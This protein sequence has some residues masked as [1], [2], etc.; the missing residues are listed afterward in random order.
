MGLE[1][2]LNA[3]LA[4]AAVTQEGAKDATKEAKKIR[5][6]SKDLEEQLDSMGTAEAL[7]NLV[8]QLGSTETEDDLKKLFDEIDEDKSGTLEVE[9]LQ[10]VFK[11]KLKIEKTKEEIEQV[12]AEVKGAGGDLKSVDLAHFR[13][14]VDNF[15]AAAATIESKDAASS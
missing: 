7:G 8:D 3:L 15:K 4:G 10:K 2:E 11:D 1:D 12:F 13:K 5:R 14:I 6:R 9:E